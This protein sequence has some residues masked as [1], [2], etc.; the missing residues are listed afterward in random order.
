MRLFGGGDEFAKKKDIANPN[1]LTGT[2]DFS[3]NNWGYQNA[4]SRDPNTKALNGNICVKEALWSQVY[5]VVN[6]VAGQFYTFSVET[7]NGY[8]RLFA[9]TPDGAPSDCFAESS[10]TP[11]GSNTNTWHR[12]SNTWKCVKSGQVMLFEAQGAEHYVAN[13]KLEIGTVATPWCPAYADYVMKS[14]LDALKAE[15]DQL[16]QNK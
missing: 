2:A 4:A 12:F 3:G 15:I 13:M 11:Q 14:D 5:Q 7:S 16:K 1:L 9:Q 8:A 10:P 6:V